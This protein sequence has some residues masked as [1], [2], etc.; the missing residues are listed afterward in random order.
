M[1]TNEL[2]NK[3]L[4]GLKK[5][6]ISIDERVYLLITLSTIY[7]LKGDILSALKYCAIAS[8]CTPSPR[9][10]VCCMMG[11]LY[12]YSDN[13]EWAEKWYN[14]AI[15]NTTS[16]SYINP[17]YSNIIPFSKLFEIYFKKKDIKTCEKYLILIETMSP[18][19]PIIENLKNNLKTL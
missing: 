10:D 2:I 19:N 1:E 4:D 9:A 6:D 7:K 5:E 3:C 14:N 11:E 16:L 18:N 13:L 15:N 12:F 8:I 17:E